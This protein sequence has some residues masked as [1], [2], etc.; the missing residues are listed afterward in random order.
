MTETLYGRQPLLECLRAGRRPLIK[1]W[2]Q[3]GAR[4]IGPLADLLALAR[5]RQIAVGET[6]KRI[7]DRMS[8]G[9]HHQGVVLE[10]EPYPFLDPETILTETAACG[11]AALFLLLDHLQDPQNLGSLLRSADAAGVHGVFL[12]RDRCADVTPAVVRASSGACEHLRIARVP[13]LRRTLLDLRE[14]GVRVWGLEGDPAAQLYTET[15][16]D[17]P[18][19]LVVGSEGEGLTHAVRNACDGRIR[20]P[21]LGSVASL[22]AAIAGSIVLFHIRARRTPPG[23]P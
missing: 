5:A 7:L 21:M 14:R 1:M 6:D 18:V 17:G 13:N 2:V 9:G 20:I 16:L 12:P 3:T 11:E 23:R 22:N 4:R 15:P 19:G 10:A 8:Q